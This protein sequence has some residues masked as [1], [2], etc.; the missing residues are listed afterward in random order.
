MGLN[1]DIYS[2]ANTATI[3]AAMGAVVDARDSVRFPSLLA[4]GN[5]VTGVMFAS[6]R[7]T[8]RRRCVEKK[9]GEHRKQI[10]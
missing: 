8:Q 3:R 10:A 4:A 6:P 9:I 7:K 2:V 1:R 5:R